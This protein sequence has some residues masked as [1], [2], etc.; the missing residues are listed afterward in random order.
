MSVN[1]HNSDL[2]AHRIPEFDERY[3]RIKFWGAEEEF[4][5]GV[6]DFDREPA[7]ILIGQHFEVRPDLARGCVLCFYE[8]QQTCRDRYVMMKGSIG[9]FCERGL[10]KL[11]LD[12][13][14]G[15]N[16]GNGKRNV[17]KQNFFQKNFW[18]HRAY[19]SLRMKPSPRTVSMSFG[20]NSLSI[21]SLR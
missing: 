15:D 12:D 5:A 10:Q 2:V 16:S 6:D 17:Q 20:R 13:L 3:V 11:Q 8:A 21:E 18:L 19:R 4:T 14:K 7:V 1:S 9:L